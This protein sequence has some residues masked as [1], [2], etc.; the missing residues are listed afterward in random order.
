VANPNDLLSERAHSGA[1]RHMKP[2]AD[3]AAGFSTLETLYTPTNYKVEKVK[4]QSPRPKTRSP[5]NATRPGKPCALEVL[6]AVDWD[7]SCPQDHRTA[8]DS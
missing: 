7:A 3:L 1:L 2:A 8:K 6:A 4:A 5:K